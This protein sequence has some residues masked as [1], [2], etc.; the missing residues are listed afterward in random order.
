VD[1]IIITESRPSDLLAALHDAATPEM[2]FVFANRNAEP[3]DLVLVA[4]LGTEA[5]GYVAATDHGDGEV[6]VWEH[7]VAPAHRQR[8]VGRTLLYELARRVEPGA[9]VRVDP[10][11]QLDLE[12]IADYYAR[13]GF[14]HEAAKQALWGT[15]TEVLRATGRQLAGNRGVPVK[16]LLGEKA[17]GTGVVTIK[18]AAAVEE[19][20]TLL[21]HHRIG[22]VPV[23]SD[24]ARIEGIV[25]ERDIL[26]GLGQHG[27]G[28]LGR[29]VSEIMTQ[30][31]VTCTAGD[32]IELLMSLMTRLRIRHIPITDAGRLVGLVSIGDIVRHR[33]EQL[34]LE[35]QHIRDYITSG[36]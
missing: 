1:E 3:S 2:E 36:R 28:V 7:A 9:I 19:L 5:A 4:W 20:V 31:V 29:P 10:A 8:G 11:Q 32:G 35:N 17:A 30:D 13:C 27:A 23:S 14:T 26:R 24:G 22:A 12:R 6:E 34:E 21:N 33:L 18:P 25:S 15:A 16:I